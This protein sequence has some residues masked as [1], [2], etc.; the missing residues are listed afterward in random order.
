VVYAYVTAAAA[1]DGPEFQRTI[2]AQ[3]PSFAKV[4]SQG[5]LDDS[6]QRRRSLLGLYVVVH[7][8]GKIAGKCHRGS[9]HENQYIT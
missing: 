5:G 9:L 8:L 7:G 3:K 2:G 4:F 1:S 6:G